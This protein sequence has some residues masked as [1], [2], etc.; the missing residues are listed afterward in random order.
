MVV[1]IRTQFEQPTPAAL[2]EQLKSE[3]EDS[4]SLFKL[5]SFTMKQSLPTLPPNLVIFSIFGDAKLKK[6]EH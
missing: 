3:N 5:R 4:L 1:F 2:H 6:F